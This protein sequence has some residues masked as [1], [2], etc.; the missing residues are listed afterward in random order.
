MLT[1]CFIYILF[2]DMVIIFF[3]VYYP[4]VGLVLLHQSICLRLDVE[5]LLS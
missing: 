2:E 3:S 1:Q 5:S 4:I